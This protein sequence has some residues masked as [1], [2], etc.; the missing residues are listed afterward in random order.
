MDFLVLH[1]D[2]DCI[3][4][5]GVARIDVGDQEG[6]APVKVEQKHAN[7][8]ANHDPMLQSNILRQSVVVL[9]Y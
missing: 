5:E 1:F 7:R 3:V 8:P 6:E 9:A 4:P 2:V